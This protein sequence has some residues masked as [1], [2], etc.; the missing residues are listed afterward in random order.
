LKLE[1]SFTKG[2]NGCNGYDQ[3]GGNSPTQDRF[4]GHDTFPINQWLKLLV[5]LLGR[6][7]T[8]AEARRASLTLYKQIL[9]EGRKVTKDSSPLASAT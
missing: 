4:V 2:L 6:I 7:N 1:F 9:T 3:Q 5:G 8:L